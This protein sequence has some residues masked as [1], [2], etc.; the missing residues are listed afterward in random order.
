M[1]GSTQKSLFQY[2]WLEFDL[3]LELSHTLNKLPTI[4]VKPADT[5]LCAGSLPIAPKKRAL[6][7]QSQIKWSWLKVV[8][9]E[10]NP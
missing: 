5:D 4:S 8:R 1:F 9:A 7:S 2:K 10:E 3:K 6:L